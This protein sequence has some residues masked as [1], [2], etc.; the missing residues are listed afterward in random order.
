[1]SHLRENRLRQQ[2]N[3]NQLDTLLTPSEE[4]STRLTD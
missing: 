2:E 4:F 3:C 1:M